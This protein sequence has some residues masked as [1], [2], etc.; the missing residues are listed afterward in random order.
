MTSSFGRFL[1][2][3]GGLG[4]AGTPPVVTFVSPLAG[5]T[6]QK[7]T[8][9]VVDATDIDGDIETG[10]V[11]VRFKETGAEVFWKGMSP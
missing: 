9:L 10:I 11:T 8:T 5:S 1:T 3:A 4:A 2:P 7:T 6:I